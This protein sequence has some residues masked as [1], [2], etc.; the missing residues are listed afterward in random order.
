[1][2]IDEL[3]YIQRSML[4]ADGWSIDKQ[5]KGVKDS[6]LIEASK[7]GKGL[8]LSCSA[9]LTPMGSECLIAPRKL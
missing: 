4:K 2:L 7:G 9:P 8:G 5:A 3:V 1:M 6:I